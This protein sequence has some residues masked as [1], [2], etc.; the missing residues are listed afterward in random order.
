MESS[1]KQI[2]FIG[3]PLPSDV[4]K[5]DLEA[6]RCLT[7]RSFDRDLTQDE[8]LHFLRTC[9]AL[10]EHPGSHR[11]PHAQLTLDSRT[12][13]SLC[14]DG[15]ADVLR[16]LR[17][18]NLC[19]I[20]AAQLIRQL[21]V[22]YQGR[23]DWVIGSDH[24]SATISFAVASMLNAKH[25]FC[26][27]SG[28]EQIWER[29]VIEPGEVVL[30]VEDLVGSTGTLQ[31]VRDGIRKGNPHHP[32]SYAPLCLCVVRRSCDESYIFHNKPIVSLVDLRFK[33]WT[34]EECPLCKKGSVR[35]RPKANWAKLTWHN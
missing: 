16:V 1:V 13:S 2:E 20:L 12:N 5:M 6:L 8:L 25:D 29:F 34:Q 17:Y 9:N 15:Y 23:V 19:Q 28:T 35:L 24:A 4:L 22:H 31:A 14:S 27:K 33:T 7:H 18:T 30:Q 26:Q 10:W 32:V 11:R 21:R 3:L